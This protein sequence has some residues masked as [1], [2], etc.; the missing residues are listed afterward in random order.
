[1]HLLRLK[2]RTEGDDTYRV[3]L[4][5]EREREVRQTAEASFPFELTPQDEA[6]LRWYLEDYLQW[7]QDPAPKIA[8]RV[9]DRMKELG[10]GLFRAIFQ[11]NDDTRELWSSTRRDLAKTRVEIVTSIEGAT[12]LPW[13]L[14]R[15]PRTGTALALGAHSFARAQPTAALRPRLPD[16]RDRRLRVL[17]VICRPQAGEDVPFRSVAGRLVK[18]LSQEA[19]ELFDLDVLRPP[20]Y[21]QLARELNRAKGEGK[22]YHAVHFDGHGVFTETVAEGRL[23]RLLKG[24]K[25]ILLSSRRDGKHGYLL[26]EN[27]ER[28]EN[29][30]LVDG[31]ALGRLLVKTGVPVLVLNACRSAHAEPQDTPSVCPP[32]G[33]RETADATA[34]GDAVH[35]RTRALGSLAQ[36]GMDAG[37]AGVVAMRYNVYV[38]TAAQF[39]AE[40]YAAL[41]RGPSL[42]EAV[43]LGRNNLADQP[44]RE[45]AFDPIALQDWT[46]PIVYEAAPIALFTAPED[47]GKLEIR[48]EKAQ[49]T[50]KGGLDPALPPSPDSGFWGRDETLL[51]LDRAFDRH[52]IVLLHAYAGSGK[53]ATAAEFARWYVLTGGV[54]GPV[55]F[56]TFEQHQP[57]ARVLD[58]VGEVFGPN[59][60]QQ[61]IHWLALDDAQ[62]RQ[63]ALQVLSQVPV[64]W[65]WDN[66]EP[67]AGFGGVESAWSAEEQRELADFL[68]A[69]RDTKARFLLTS[70][71]EEDSWLSDLPR[72]IAVPPMPMTERLQLARALASGRGKRAEM[73]DWKPL[74]SFSDGN[75]LTL[76]VLV[77][78]ALRDK[79]SGRDEVGAF[80]KRLRAGEAAFDDEAGEGRSRSLGASLGYG[81]EHTFAEEERRQLALLHLFQGF[82]DVQVLQAMGNSDTTWCL[83][84]VRGLDRETAMA[85]LDRAAKVGLLR[86]HGG[87]YYGIHPALPWFFRELFEEHYGASREAAMRAFVEATGELGDYYHRQYQDGNRDVIGALR[88]EEANLLQ[89]RRLARFHGWWRRVISAMQGLRVL[90]GH[91]GRRAEWKQLVEEIVPEFVEP[92]TEGP[93]AGREE[94]WSLV[95]PYRVQLAQ[96]ERSWAEAER[97]QQADVAFERQRAAPFLALP[98]QSLAGGERNTVRNLAASLHELGQIRRE[99]ESA[100]CVASYEESLELSEAIGEGSLAA[101]CAFNLGHAYRNLAAVRDLAQADH[102]YR[103]SLEL[104]DER[105]WMGRGRSLGQLGHVAFKRFQAARSRESGE[106]Q[107]VGHLNEAIDFYTRALELFPQD[108]VDELAVTHNQLGAIYGDAG[109]VDS[110]LPHYRDSIRY[111]EQQGNVY[112]ASGTRF[113]VA[114]DLLQ[115]GRP[116]DALEYALAAL[117]GFETYGESAA[118]VIQQTRQLIGT[119]EE[120]RAGE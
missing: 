64:L 101:T 14:L 9:E 67:V 78:Q 60:E 100:D 13:E 74:L 77:G 102:W 90:Y 88:A 118:E 81:F 10:T 12:A 70:R 89:A 26:F 3:E 59:L 73:K 35:A 20:T 98:R 46:V 33:E 8:A 37:V 94:L 48:L 43:T 51:A 6:D 34:A 63:L 99:M 25:P 76:T 79:L 66:V 57:L 72:R 95:N 61:R 24:L 113:N 117:R 109:D 83:Q 69:A 32:P 52:K 62:R 5:V 108:A 97:L 29:V 54:E 115:S 23:E 68:R 58:R 15:D 39:V 104:R 38:V 111:E 80:V 114:L 22:P 112:G 44:M 4:T 7:P 110:A 65:I 49:I 116:R 85:L 92:G 119:I 93:R 86:S 75:P 96:E 53:T 41:S 56:T 50:D 91:T 40:L 87:G 19:R 30:E 84:S 28:D 55:L 11:A 42:G 16:G 17:L 103:R 21:E 47:D 18:G 71:R 36:E 1:M 120:Q 106:D 31:P 45:V 27:P 107:L 2:Q 105:D 82:V